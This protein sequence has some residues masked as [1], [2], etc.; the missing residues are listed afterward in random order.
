MADDD[1]KLVSK[2]LKTSAFAENIFATLVGVTS[3]TETAETG[4]L[5]TY[6]EFKIPYDPSLAALHGVVLYLTKRATMAGN[7]KHILEKNNRLSVASNDSFVMSRGS[8]NYSYVDG[9]PRF[10]PC[11]KYEDVASPSLGS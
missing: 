11:C 7:S 4:I 5:G 8:L 3:K 2:V 1:Q 6:N 9:Q 10:C